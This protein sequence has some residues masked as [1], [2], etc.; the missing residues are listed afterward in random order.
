MDDLHKMEEEMKALK[1]RIDDCKKQA[2]LKKVHEECEA[3]KAKHMEKVRLMKEAKAKPEEVK[4]EPAPEA[5]PEPAPEAK[6][7][8]KLAKARRVPAKKA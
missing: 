5:K 1:L 3:K 7:E 4:A 2:K 8:S 6:P